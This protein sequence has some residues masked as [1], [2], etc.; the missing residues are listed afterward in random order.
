M[1]E[2]SEQLFNAIVINS[3]ADLCWLK[4]GEAAWQLN[5]M[6]IAKKVPRRSKYKFA[7]YWVTTEAIALYSTKEGE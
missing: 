3:N 2:V 6:F 1:E 5:G 4:T 7:Q